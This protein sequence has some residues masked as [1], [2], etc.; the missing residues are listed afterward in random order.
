LKII[1]TFFQVILL[2]CPTSLTWNH[3]GG[4]KLPSVLNGSPLDYLPCSP[5]V[6]P[7]R[8]RTNNVLL[9]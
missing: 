7:M 9:R 3:L 6:L 4:G 1:F 8:Q 5:V 2:E